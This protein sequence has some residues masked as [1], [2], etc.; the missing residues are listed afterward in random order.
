MDLL[1]IFDDRG[2][3]LSGSCTYNPDLFDASTITRM[4]HHWRT[5]LTAIVADPN[6]RIADLPLLTEGERQQTLVEWNQTQREYPQ[7]SLPE[8]IEAQVE[9]TPEVTA[10]MYEQEQFSY[11]ELNARANQLAHYLRKLGVGPDVLVGI[12]VE[13]ST[14]MIVTL[15]GILKAGGAYVPLDPAYPEERL[16]FM[17]KDSGLQLLIT[18]DPLHAKLGKYVEKVVRVDKDWPLISHESRE[19]PAAKAK[20]ENLAYVIYTSGSTGV[21]KGVQ[22]C[23]RSLVNLLTSI[24]TCPG[25]NE[26]DAL[27]AVTTIRSE[28]HTS[29][30][31]SRQYLVCRLLLEK[32]KK[33]KKKVI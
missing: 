5:L 24:R 14:N 7:K 9:R 28:E 10:V 25:L 15:L 6:Q 21:P 20:P 30:L 29:E 33:K 13:R 31:Q 22:I 19:N 11:R 2:D 4:V 3:G 16:A 12:C 18:H 1:V 27:L 23:H 32:K 26:T 17:I 8:L